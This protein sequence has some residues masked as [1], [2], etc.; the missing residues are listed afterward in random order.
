MV[1]RGGIASVTRCRIRRQCGWDL[2]GSRGRCLGAGSSPW[3]GS[4]HDTLPLRSHQDET[5]GKD[6]IPRSLPGGPGERLP[7]ADDPPLEVL[8]WLA[9]W[10]R[11]SRLWPNKITEPIR[12]SHRTKE[13]VGYAQLERTLG[14]VEQKRHSDVVPADRHGDGSVMRWGDVGSGRWWWS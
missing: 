11:R 14:F 2:P 6:R 4:H 13:V 8:R 7:R 12:I 5:L 3:S 9:E 1:C 10:G